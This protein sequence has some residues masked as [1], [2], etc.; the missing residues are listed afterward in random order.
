MINLD[1]KTATNSLVT[2]QRLAVNMSLSPAHIQKSS[3][4]TERV[5]IDGVRNRDVKF[6]IQIGSDWP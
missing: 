5:K 2:N 3:V 1:K 4:F 6:A